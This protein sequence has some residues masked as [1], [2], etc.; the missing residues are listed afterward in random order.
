MANWLK[1]QAYATLKLCLLGDRIVAS[2]GDRLL[3]GRGCCD[4]SPQEI[5]VALDVCCMMS[6]MRLILVAL[7]L[8]IIARVMGYYSKRLGAK[9]VSISSVSMRDLA[10]RFSALSSAHLPVES[11]QAMVFCI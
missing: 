4:L 10:L 7:A 1:Q 11:L 6:I 3:R 8:T 2:T 5:L 9:K